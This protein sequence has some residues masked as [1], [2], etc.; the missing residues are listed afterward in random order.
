MTRAAAVCWPGKGARGSE[1]AHPAA[2]NP[3]QEGDGRG[4]RKDIVA[5]H[6]KK[7][8]KGAGGLQHGVLVRYLYA[9]SKKERRGLG[10]L[11]G[12]GGKLYNRK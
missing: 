1:D 3:G 10:A 11:A 6:R 4:G 5:Q 9:K 12:Y 7:K 8:K 2:H